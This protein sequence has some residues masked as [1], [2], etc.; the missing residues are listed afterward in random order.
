MAQVCVWLGACC[1]GC[2][3]GCFNSIFS[4]GALTSSPTSGNTIDSANKLVWVGGLI[5]KNPGGTFNHFE[6]IE[7]KLFFS[8]PNQGET[9]KTTLWNLTPPSSH[10]TSL[11]IFLVGGFNPFEKYD[12]QIGSSPQVGMN[13]KN[14][15]N[16]HP[17]DFFWLDSTSSYRFQSFGPWIWI[18][19]TFEASLVVQNSST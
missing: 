15:W 19:P 1:C 6:E 4:W 11:N 17:A 14:L 13:M 5:P 2:L 9:K 3:L 12:R 7:V 18:S 16:H 10:S 8:S